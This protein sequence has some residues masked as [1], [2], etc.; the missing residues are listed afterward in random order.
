MFNILLIENRTGG[1]ATISTRQ[2][3]G[4]FKYLIMD[5]LKLIVQIARVVSF[6]FV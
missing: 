5:I 4:F 1:S 2:T 3:I 6:E